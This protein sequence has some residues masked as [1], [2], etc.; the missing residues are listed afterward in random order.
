MSVYILLCMQS[1][2]YLPCEEKNSNR[3]QREYYYALGAEIIDFARKKFSKFLA[4]LWCGSCVV[5]TAITNYPVVAV[6]KSNTVH[7]LST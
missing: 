1:L 4:T 6:S 7:A 2:L 3:L 5:I